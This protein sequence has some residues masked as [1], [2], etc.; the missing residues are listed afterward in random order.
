MTRLQHSTHQPSSG[1]I[2]V[3]RWFNS[4]SVSPYPLRSRLS[5]L[6]RLLCAVPVALCLCGES[7]LRFLPVRFAFSPLLR[8]R[9]GSKYSPPSKL[10]Q[11]LAAIALAV[12]QTAPLRANE[13]PNIAP[14]SPAEGV[15]IE[16][17][18]GNTI[19]LDNRF[20]NESGTE[21]ELGKFFGRRPVVLMLGYYECPML[22]NQ[23]L[24]GLIKVLNGVD[25]QAGKDFELVVVSIAP[26]ETPTMGLRKRDAFLAQYH[27]GAQAAAGVH[28]L[29]GKEPNIRR[30]A[31]EVGYHYRYEPQARRYAHAAGV[32]IATPSGKL[33]RYFYGIDYSTRDMRYAL[34]EAADERLG[35][36]V[37][38][39]LLLCFHYDPTTGRYGLAIMRLMR[40]AGLLTVVCLGGFIA[41]MIRRERRRPA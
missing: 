27:H 6:S 15:A 11:A 19:S 3:H 21:V 22:C 26:D 14:P 18:L 41:L 1:F 32:M 23:V 16:Q 36:A 24:H 34:I 39:V 13:A 38:Q 31:E 2:G 40:V 30:L 12:C 17:R 5:F 28:F 20:L 4:L 25:F 10:L 35:S 9:S 33:A 7:L 8:F 37:D 29:C